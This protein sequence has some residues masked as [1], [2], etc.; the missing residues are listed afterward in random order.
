MSS[1]P[2]RTI[3][4]AALMALTPFALVACGGGGDTAAADHADHAGHDHAD[5]AGHD[6]ADHAKPA[7]AAADAGGMAGMSGEKIDPTGA[8][9]AFDSA[10]AIGSKG[11]CP[12][13]G[14]AFL[15]TEKTATSEHEGKHYGYCCPGCKPK[16]DADP[17]KY[18]ADASAP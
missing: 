12:V 13:S 17:A 16:F 7:E 4:T 3:L 2:F 18:L 8:V 14:Q 1:T 11:I 5:H 15:V 10:P 6:H 9:K